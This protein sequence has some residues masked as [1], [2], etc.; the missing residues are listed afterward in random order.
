[1]KQ[2][3]D[4]AALRLA[5]AVKY[6]SAGTVEFL[7]DDQGGFYFLEMN[8]RLQVEH[9]VTELVTGIDLVCAQ[10]AQAQAPNDTI[11]QHA[12]EARGHAIEVRLYAEDPA[13][14]FM[15][16]PG[17]VERLRWPSGPGIRVDS[18]I[19]EGQTIGT[20]FDSMLAKLI[21][22]A[23]NRDHAIHRLRYALEETVI[24][25]IGTNQSYLL[26]LTRDA[27]VLEGRVHTGYLGEAY[28][29]FAPELSAGEAA[30]LE[31]A[32][33]QGLA[34]AAASAAATG[35]TIP[36]PWTVFGGPG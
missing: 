33:S 34:R 35:S 10:L 15:P 16:T 30:L 25:G 7:V 2:G 12:P 19:E 32:R 31:G 3:L 9:P 27:K 8:T 14:G 21:V 23:P 6:R 36:S 24:L 11:L 26:A 5:R 17:R 29:K 28:A 22:H 20:Q 13:Q 4:E 1:V 18:G